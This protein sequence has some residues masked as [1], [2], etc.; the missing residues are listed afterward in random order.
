MTRFLFPTL[1]LLIAIGLFFAYINPAYGTVQELRGERDQVQQA[2]SKAKE[3]QQLRERLLSQFN[4]FRTRDLER[5]Q[6][7]L[8]AN[9]DN[10]RLVLDLSDL[11]ANFGMQIQD[12]QLTQSEGTDGGNERQ[13]AV[14]GQ[15]DVAYQSRELSFTVVSDYRTFT[16]F[17]RAIERSLRLLDVT[18]LSF[19]SADDSD[20]YE[21]TVTVRTYWLP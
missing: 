9:I 4:S 3:L 19:E 1:F 15:D 14:T 21:F 8:P 17:L 11:A 12:L 10:V 13:Q 7:L 20:L 2:L 18:G 5:A 16:E 6:K